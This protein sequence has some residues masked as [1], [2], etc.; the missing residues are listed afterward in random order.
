MQTPGVVVEDIYGTAYVAAGRVLPGPI[1]VDAQAEATGAGTTRLVLADRGPAVAQDIPH[2]DAAVIRR[3][4]QVLA[5][6]A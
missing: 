1:Q 2:V 4:S 5:V 6:L 3:R